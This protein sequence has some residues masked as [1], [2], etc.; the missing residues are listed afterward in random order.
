MPFDRLAGDP[1]GLL[2]LVASAAGAWRAV[3]FLE[4]LGRAGAGYKA[5]VL[6]SAVFVCG[7]AP[8]DA[9]AADVRF[10]DYRI[11]R[12]FRASVD[13]ARRRV[14]VRFLGLFT[15]RTAVYRPGL[16][17]AL[18]EGCPPRLSG[19]ASAPAGDG[20]AASFETVPAPPALAELVR[21]AFAEPD[22]AKLRRTRALLVVKDG[23]LLAEAYAPGFGPDTPLCGWSMS[24]SVLGVLV[25]AAAGRGLLSPSDRGLLPEWSGPGDPR[26]ALTLEDLLRMRSGLEFA[27]RYADPASDVVQSLFALPDA[28]GYA[29][30]K[31]L[32]QPPGVEW[33]YASGTS[34]LVSRV[35]RRA[36][37]RRG[38][39]YHRFPREALFGPLG[40]GTAV[41]ETD[42]AGTFVGSSF[43]YAA[44]RD[45]ARLGQLMLQDGVWEGRR[46]LPEGWVRFL[47]AP[48]PQAP[49]ACYGAH[50]WLKVARE[51]GGD[52]EAA[53]RLPPDAYHALGHEAQCLTVVPSRRL[54]VVRMG[55]SVRVDAW[56]HAEFLDEL[57]RTV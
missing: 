14:T 29:A 47:T 30:D 16:G 26:A 27:E 57:L 7:R 6:A 15:P 32:A 10:D 28:A 39:D 31:P 13:A 43:V 8:E 33:R 56:N 38:L 48:T 11:L 19:P 51:M 40:L 25:G 41:F 1:I 9:L 21:S 55:L 23:R 46:L 53:R 4:R 44:P 2:L 49:D 5:K 3:G 42:A 50:W 37:E 24:K 22:P 52:S 34:N 36:L 12:L 54:V 45:W 18:A 17:C 20:K 35:L